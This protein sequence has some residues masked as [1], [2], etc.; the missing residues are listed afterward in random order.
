M[1]SAARPA[2]QVPG[3][4]L[5]VRCTDPGLLIAQFVG[6][7]FDAVNEGILRSVSRS[8]DLSRK[9]WTHEGKTGLANEL[10]V[11]VREGLDL[12]EPIAVEATA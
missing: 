6:L 11:I 2:L 10:A 12:A 7:P 4:A 3:P 8:V 1:S 5:Q 9:L